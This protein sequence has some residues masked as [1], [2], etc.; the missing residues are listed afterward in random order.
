[1]SNITTNDF[2][3][4]DKLLVKP[5]EGLRRF[6]SDIYPYAETLVTVKEILNYER[7]RIEE[8][9]EDWMW[10]TDAISEVVYS[11]VKIKNKIKDNAPER[12]FGLD[13]T[14]DGYK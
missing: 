4:G 1:M 9:D 10:T 11:E 12:R 3:V 5:V 13:I 6:I 7:F 2:E 8:D 14:P